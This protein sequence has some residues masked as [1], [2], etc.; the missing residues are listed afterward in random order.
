MDIQIL[1]VDDEPQFLEMSRTKWEKEGEKTEV[2]TT[3]DPKEALEKIDATDYD[4]IV[5]DYKMPEMT[6]LELLKKVRDRGFETPFIILTAKGG[7]EV[8]MEALNLKADR[9]LKKNMSPEKQ[10]EVIVETIYEKPVS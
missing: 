7:E 1:L 4:V 6:G 2:D 10:F 5:A 3:T 9:Y 8:A